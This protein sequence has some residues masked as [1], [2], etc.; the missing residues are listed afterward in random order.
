MEML[1]SK[2]RRSRFKDFATLLR[3]NLFRELILSGEQFSDKVIERA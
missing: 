3:E 1:N 2:L